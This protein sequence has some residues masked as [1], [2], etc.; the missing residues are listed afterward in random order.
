MKT[1]VTARRTRLLATAAAATFVLTVVGAG[2]AAAHDPIFVVEDQ[3]TPDEGPYLPD[4]AIS[5]ALYGSVLGP[6]DTRG[7]EFDLREGEE[8]YISLLIPNLE[9]E[10]SLADDELP[11]IELETPDG[12]TRTLVNDMRETFNEPFSNTSYL[13]LSEVREPAQEGR[14]RGL[15][16]GSAPSRFT[17]AIGEREEFFTPAERTGDRPSSF[18]GIAAPLQAWYSTPPGEEVSV[19]L[20]EGEGEIEMEMIEEAIEEGAGS[21][22]A[23][24]LEDGTS[25][26]ALDDS[27]ADEA[28]GENTTDADGSLGWVAPAAAAVAVVLGAA[29]VLTR[30]R[31]DAA[32]EAAPGDA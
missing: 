3:T 11:V 1:L 5:W 15:V 27:T 10:L 18:P 31:R 9:P 24:A 14:Y 20:A 19:D 4:G 22:P 23:E 32:S 26:E 21:A 7:F 25:E 29:W 13:T 2:P 6:G 12:T 28:L 16:V 17:V 30:R 8:L